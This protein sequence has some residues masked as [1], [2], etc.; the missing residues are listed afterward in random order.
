MRVPLIGGCTHLALLI[1]A[2]VAMANDQQ[3]SA[4]AIDQALRPLLDSALQRYPASDKVRV[5]E[6]PAQQRFELG[7][8][9]D[10]RKSQ[11]DGVPVLAVSPG[12]AAERIGLHSGDRMQAINGVG[13]LG[14]EDAAARIADGLA[15]RDGAIHLTIARGGSSLQLEGMVDVIDIPAYR[16]TIGPLP[17]KADAHGTR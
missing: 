9:L 15:S 17:A 13:L 16:M 7:A 14:V 5:I 10:V 2:G 3:P 8:V 1:G 12:S 6:Q 4:E 11:P